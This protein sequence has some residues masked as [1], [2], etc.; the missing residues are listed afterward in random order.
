MENKRILAN[1]INCILEVVKKLV[2]SD[3]YILINRYKNDLASIGYTIE[4]FE[5]TIQELTYENYIE[6]PN[7]NNKHGNN[8]WI[9]GYDD[10]EQKIQIY[11]KF[12]IDKSKKRICFISF[13]KAERELEYFDWR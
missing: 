10:N 3:K 11:I 2:E 9:F 8:V 5:Y 1:K 12:G 7:F 4:L 13:H 6:G